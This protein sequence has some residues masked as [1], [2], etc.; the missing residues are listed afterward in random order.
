MHKK[1]TIYAALFTLPVLLF[2]L[3]QYFYTAA[4]LWPTG[5]TVNENV[6]YLSYAKQYSDQGAF[7][8][9]YANPFD[10]DP[11]SPR[12]YF[13]PVM[14]L[15]SGILRL[16]ADPGLTFSIFG[17]LMAFGCIYTGLR[18][19]QLLLKKEDSIFLPG[20]LFT[21]GGG[22]LAL[23]GYAAWQLLPGY[24]AANWQD[25][26][27]LADPAWGWWG[28]NW[29]RNLFIPLEA[30]YHL[31]FLLAI[32]FLLTKRWKSGLL[33][34]ILLS[35]SHPF[36]GIEYL[37]IMNG[38]LLLE[39][40]VYRNKTIPAWY[41]TGHLLITLFHV[42]YYLIWLNRFPEHRQLFNQY[43]ASWTYSLWIAVP[44]YLLAGLLAMAGILKN[45]TQA[46]TALPVQ[47]LFICWAIISFLLSKHEW[48]IRPMQPL[49][50]TRGYTWAALFL[51]ALPFISW[52]Q[53]DWKN[54]WQKPLLTALIVLLLADN[55]IWTY[56][57]LRDK[58]TGESES[59]L[60][61]ETRELLMFLQKTA[62]PDDLLTGNAPLVLYTA[63][64]YSSANA[65]I[66][67]PYNTPDIG[68]RRKKMEQ[69]LASGQPL[70]EWKNRRILIV[71]DKENKKSSP[72]KPELLQ[73]KIFENPRYILSVL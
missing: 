51:A 25:A 32:C 22:L 13:Q 45:K 69:F 7:S 9:F 71:L 23:T 70:P 12:I 3:H 27:H 67:H 40:I 48:F 65:W 2:L 55:S 29:G 44:A 60:K 31:L 66:S 20:L 41:M 4:G 10:G 35:L 28:L 63:N 50:F 21:W 61:A 52:L 68:T 57:L 72:I 26:T 34:A 64:V 59:H 6:L 38:W 18:I 17:L 11:E 15:L 47:R 39:K 46:G 53:H 49:H 30:F 42:W 43:S 24:A 1:T 8:L 62:R 54:K 16:G 37:L 73:K 58:N 5:I 14:L 56:T 19:I 33:T 36:T